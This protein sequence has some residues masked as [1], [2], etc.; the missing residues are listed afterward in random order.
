MRKRLVGIVV[1]LALLVLV[2]ASVVVVNQAVQLID[3]AYRLH[4]TAGDAAF[5]SLAALAVFCVGVPVVMLLTMPPALIPPDEDA[6]PST[7]STLIGCGSDLPE[8]LTWTASR[9][10]LPT[11]RHR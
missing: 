1:P 8:T 7:R 6:A 9:S 10:P 11:S 3:L 5:W 4:P 2:G